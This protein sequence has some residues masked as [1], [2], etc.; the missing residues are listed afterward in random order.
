MTLGGLI[1]LRI[2]VVEHWKVGYREEL[3][4]GN[5]VERERER[6]MEGRN[7][8]RQQEKSRV[9]ERGRLV[10]TSPTRRF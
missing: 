10:T 2:T 4:I 1:N 9:K 6:E 5:G 3:G 8:R 7:Q